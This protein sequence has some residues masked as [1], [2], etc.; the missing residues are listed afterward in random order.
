[1]TDQIKATPGLDNPITQFPPWKSQETENAQKATTVI[2]RPTPPSPRTHRPILDEGRTRHQI[3]HA[4]RR[5]QMAT[6]TNGPIS[7]RLPHLQTRQRN[8]RSHHQP[9]QT[10]RNRTNRRTTI[11]QRHPKQTQ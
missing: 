10:S 9:L 3:P 1:M 8:V 6:P 11:T 5:L 7:R 4:R 2:T